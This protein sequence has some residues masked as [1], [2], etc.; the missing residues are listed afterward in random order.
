[1]MPI[2]AID[3]GEKRIGI[4]IS[5]PTDTLARPLTIVVHIS[6]VADA[7]HVMEI[8]IEHRVTAIVIGQSTDEE[9]VLNPAGRRAA[10]FAEVL[11][12]M[13]ELPIRLW[14]ESLS[15]RDALQWRI[16][17][18]KSRK[19]RAAHDDAVAA[20]VILQSYFEAQRHPETDTGE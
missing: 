6:Q 7:R 1:M 18:G 15:T 17:S 4:A 2:L 13:T 5:D 11:R 19:R 9:G 12:G 8:A 20:A 3:H 10:R 16:E 14:D